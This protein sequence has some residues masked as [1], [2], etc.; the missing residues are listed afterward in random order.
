MYNCTQTHTHTKLFTIHSSGHINSIWWK[1][2]R[3][4]QWSQS[5]KD[6]STIYYM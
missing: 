6:N 1:N 5:Q 3:S 2:C 4:K